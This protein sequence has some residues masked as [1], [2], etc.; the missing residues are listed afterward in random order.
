MG[1]QKT[2]NLNLLLEGMSFRDLD[3]YILKDTETKAAG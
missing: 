1:K 3:I 2:V